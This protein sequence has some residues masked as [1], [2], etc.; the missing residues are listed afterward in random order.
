[1]VSVRNSAPARWCGALA[2]GGALAMGVMA[3][4]ATPAFAA[5]PL[6]V[7]QLFV[8]A[9]PGGG[10]GGA[11]PAT[12]H[13]GG[14]HGAGIGTNSLYDTSNLAVAGENNTPTA[15][16]VTGG[17]LLAGVGTIMV[18]R[19]RRRRN[20]NRR[21]EKNKMPDQQR[22]AWAIAVESLRMLGASPHRKEEDGEYKTIRVRLDDG[23]IVRGA[24]EETP[25][26]STADDNPEDV[27]F[28]ALLTALVQLELCPT[29]PQDN[30]LELPIATSFVAIQYLAENGNYDADALPA[31][32]EKKYGDV[33]I[34]IL[35]D[36]NLYTR[37]MYTI[38]FHV[39]MGI[40]VNVQAPS[41]A[42]LLA[43]ALAT[44]AYLSGEK[45]GAEILQEVE[46]RIRGQVA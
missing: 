36:D 21:K 14:G 11:M 22:I 17:L 35:R 2:A 25:T 18:A 9:E 38:P 7:P 40:P 15:L 44:V 30:T 27:D 43:A 23:H 3:V 8:V 16:F 45:N 29:A 33:L 28:K 20:M 10:A 46:T 37:E 6:S 12:N 32:V 26:T 31:E 24:N 34:K 13:V 41:M 19:S 4:G 1:M 39:A 42:S 5:H